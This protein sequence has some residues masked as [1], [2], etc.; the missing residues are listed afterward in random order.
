MT[1]LAGI[2]VAALAATAA[3][4]PPGTSLAG[5]IAALNGQTV[6]SCGGF[7][8]GQCTALGCAWARNLGLGTPCGSCGTP[9]HCDGACW[10]GSGYAGWTWIPYAAG[11][12]P[13]PGDLVSYHANCAANGIGASGHVDIFVSGSASSFT[14]FAQNWNGPT[15]KLVNHGYACVTGWQHPTTALGC[16]GGCPAGFSCVA[17]H[18]VAN[19]P[20]PPLGT[21]DWTSILLWGGAGALAFAAW[22]PHVRALLDA[23]ETSTRRGR[24]GS[25]GFQVRTRS[26]VNPFSR[27]P[28]P[29]GGSGFS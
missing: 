9:D 10:S 22:R 8:A 26:P 23:R 27:P 16:A 24:G 25:G 19:P 4:P 18:C 6:D 2:D 21:A 5:F 20:P 7:P 17:G 13:T 28:R 1:L 15:C 11:R 12:V 14:S 3:L 29:S